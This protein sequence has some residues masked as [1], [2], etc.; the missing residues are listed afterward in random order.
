MVIDVRSKTEFGICH[1]PESISKSTCYSGVH[2]SVLLLDIPLPILMG[3]PSSCLPPRGDSE[4]IYVVCRLGNDSQI[5]A[6]ALRKEIENITI[7]DVIGGLRSW[8]KDVDTN[9]PIY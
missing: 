4:E 1:L 9:F 7:K 6:E 3:R 2:R 8:S 5:A